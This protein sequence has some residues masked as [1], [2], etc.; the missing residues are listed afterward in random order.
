M[1]QV[2]GSNPWCPKDKNKDQMS[3]VSRSKAKHTKDK[4]ED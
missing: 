1:V 3:K 4:H 2:S